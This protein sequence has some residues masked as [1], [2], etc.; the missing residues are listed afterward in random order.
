V[1][2]MAAALRAV[3]HDVAHNEQS[4][5]RDAIFLRF[6]NK[7]PLGTLDL[8]APDALVETVHADDGRSQRAWKRAGFGSAL[9]LA[10]AFAVPWDVLASFDIPPYGDAPDSFGQLAPRSGYGSV[11]SSSTSGE[12]C[13]DSRL[14]ALSFRFVRRGIFRRMEPSG[15]WLIFPRHLPGAAD[16]RNRIDQVR[17]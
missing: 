8:K 17:G 4:S 1:E 10:V 13:V 15:E 12:A 16:P 11:A 2:I 5:V 7:E 6:F 9:L 3:R 14:R